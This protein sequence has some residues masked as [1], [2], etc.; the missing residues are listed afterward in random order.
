MVEHLVAPDVD[1]RFLFY[2][3]SNTNIFL[4]INKSLESGSE[5]VNLNTAN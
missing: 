4:M 2:P 3:L 5:K 1:M